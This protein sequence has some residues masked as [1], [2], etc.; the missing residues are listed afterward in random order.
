MNVDWVADCQ[1][2][3]EVGVR[4]LRLPQVGPLG[5]FVVLVGVHLVPLVRGQQIV[6]EDL[7]GVVG[8]CASW[9]L[10]AFSSFAFCVVVVA[11]PVAVV[12]GTS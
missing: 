9:G 1:A 2:H 6:L 5:P 3:Q 7:E 12:V 4:G 10:G 8:A 11:E